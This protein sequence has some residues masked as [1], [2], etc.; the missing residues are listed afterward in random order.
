MNSILYWM[1]SNWSQCYIEWSPTEH[2]GSECNINKFNAIMNGIPLKSMLYWM[3]SHWIQC[4]WME[5]QWV[6]CYIEWN[7]TEVNGIECNI[8]EFN[9]IL[10]GVPLNTMELNVTSVNSILYWMESHWSQC[11]IECS[12]TE[13]NGSNVTSMNS[14]L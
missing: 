4:Y 1:E 9:V 2:N 7:P 11:Y 5:H 14:L 6:L 12:P 13:H 10:N 8:N 3:E